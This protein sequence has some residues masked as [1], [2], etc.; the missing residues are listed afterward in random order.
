MSNLL[1]YIRQCMSYLLKSLLL[2]DIDFLETKDSLQELFLDKVTFL[3]N[4][5][6]MDP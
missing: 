2:F 3:Y 1:N 5:K 6:L 4:L